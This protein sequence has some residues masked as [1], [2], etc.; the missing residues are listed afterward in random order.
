MREKE[1]IVF[2]V[3]SGIARYVICEIKSFFSFCHSSVNVIREKF[4]R[5]LGE[6]EVCVMGEGWVKNVILWVTFLN[7]RK[8]IFYILCKIRSNKT[9]HILNKKCVKYY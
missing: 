1:H 9:S 8:M 5:G 4:E 7:G 6:K 3:S 2:S